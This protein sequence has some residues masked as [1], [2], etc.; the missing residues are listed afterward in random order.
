MTRLVVRAR[1][2]EFP[3]GGTILQ[4]FPPYFMGSPMVS[5]RFS[6]KTRFSRHGATR[7]GEDVSALANGASP[8]A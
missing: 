6:H 7:P 1:S 5:G 4:A 3:R 8:G 2:S